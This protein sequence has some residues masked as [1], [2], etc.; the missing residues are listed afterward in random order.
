MTHFLGRNP[1]DI[2]LGPAVIEGVL[3]VPLLLLA[4]L[5][6]IASPVAIYFKSGPKL[7]QNV[8][9]PSQGAWSWMN[10]VTATGCEV[11]IVGL[12]GLKACEPN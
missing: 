3:I 9:V 1:R 5:L 12:E 11:K 8:S 4:I 2:L 7:H 10:F 6:M